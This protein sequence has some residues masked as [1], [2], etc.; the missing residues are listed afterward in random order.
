MKLL[1]LIVFATL[2]LGAS[3]SRAAPQP[4]LALE[5]FELDGATT[6]EQQP[7]V[8]NP[9]DPFCLW[10]ID[11]FWTAGG[12]G[13]MAPGVLSISQCEIADNQ[14]RIVGISG[15][16]TSPDL[17][18]TLSFEP[19]GVSFTLAPI[20]RDRKTWD[21]GGCVTGPIHSTVSLLPEIPDS[22]GGHGV[23][24]MVTLTVQNSTGRV[25]RNT[26]IQLDTGSDSP[27]TIRRS[28]CRGEQ[29]WLQTAG[30][31]WRTGL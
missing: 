26:L 8:I 23:Y 9:T 3:I 13:D 20:V 11:D 30:A 17:V 5:T 25:L 12:F 31:M 15:Y 18:V 2:I 21:Y 10:D 6:V 22:N 4:M 7:G 27:G 14:H 19:Q 28:Y 1:S 24:T 29:V 16:A